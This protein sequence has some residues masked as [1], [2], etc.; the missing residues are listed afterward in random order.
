MI[1]Y[2]GEYNL[3]FFGHDV[4]ETVMLGH[5]RAVFAGVVDYE[6]ELEKNQ[7]ALLYTTQNIYLVGKLAEDAPVP[8]P[9]TGTLSLLAL[10]GLCARRR[11]K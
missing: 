9:T 4:G 10:A 2:G 3:Q 8:E 11:R 6:W 1:I 5:T 7:I